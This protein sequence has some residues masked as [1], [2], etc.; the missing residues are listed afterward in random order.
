M[1]L[2][3]RPR[4]RRVGGVEP[5]APINRIPEDVLSLIPSYCNT[6]GELV[7]LTHVCRGSRE[8]FISCSSL[9]TFLDCANVKQ[10]RVYLERSKTSPL[11]LWLGEEEDPSFLNDAFLLPVLHLDRLRFLTLSG[12]RTTCSNLPSILTPS[13]SLPPG[14][15]LWL[16]RAPSSMGTSRHYASYACLE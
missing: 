8:R 7:T 6:G 10:T 16:F 14:P 2:C 4:T 5:F 12:P 9:W 3:D 1:F 15:K 13:K 11:E